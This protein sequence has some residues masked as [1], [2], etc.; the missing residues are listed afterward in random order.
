[1]RHAHRDARRELRGAVRLVGADA[2]FLDVGLRE[3]RLELLGAREHEAQ[4]REILLRRL[5]QVERQER[6]RA[7]EHRAA[8]LAH[9][10]DDGLRVER[11]RVV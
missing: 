5:A 6:G 2:E 3:R 1:M 8:V 4:R 10:V 7:E 11:T 9:H